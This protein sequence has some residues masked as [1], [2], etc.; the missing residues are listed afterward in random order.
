VVRILS[1]S[2]ATLVLVLHGAKTTWKK[3]CGSGILH[4]W[5]RTDALVFGIAYSAIL[6]F[7]IRAWLWTHFPGSGADFLA[8]KIGHIKNLQRVSL[9]IYD[10]TDVIF[11]RLEH[12]DIAWFA[13][14]SNFAYGISKFAW[15][16]HIVSQ[17]QGLCHFEIVLAIGKGCNGCSYS[18]FTQWKRW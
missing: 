18:F 6:L 16:L 9:N 14:H 1:V 3:R 2:M 8:Y 17:C 4:W 5:S 11:Y 10:D 12:H 15:K 13:K 7:C